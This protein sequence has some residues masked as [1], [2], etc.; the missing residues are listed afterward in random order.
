MIDH[1]FFKNKV[2]LNTVGMG[3]FGNTLLKSFFN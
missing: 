2:L 1:S 3:S